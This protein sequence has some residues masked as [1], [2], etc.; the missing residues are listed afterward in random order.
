MEKDYVLRIQK[1]N[2]HIN[3]VQRNCYKLG[4]KL[5]ELDNH[6]FGRILI[7]N[8]QIHDTNVPENTLIS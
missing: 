1:V 7:S 8:G 5:I 4:M 6:E 3:N 2:E